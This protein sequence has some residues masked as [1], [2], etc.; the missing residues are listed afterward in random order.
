MIDKLDHLSIQKIYLSNDNIIKLNKQLNSLDNLNYLIYNDIIDYIFS[1]K[2]EEIY[3]KL[4]SSYFYSSEFK[5]SIV[6]NRYFTL[7]EHIKL[8]NNQRILLF[9]LKKELFNSYITYGIDSNLFK[10]KVTKY[11]V[12]FEKF[13]HI[14]S[15]LFLE[16][17]KY[18][19]SHYL[20]DMDINNSKKA[21]GNC[22]RKVNLLDSLNL[23]NESEMGYLY[24]DPY[25]NISNKIGSYFFNK[26]FIKKS[27][28]YS[29]LYFISLSIGFACFNHD[30]NNYVYQLMVSKN[31]Y[32]LLD[33]IECFLEILIELDIETQVDLIEIFIYIYTN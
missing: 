13:I 1:R 2:V 32:Q 33:I 20:L 7:N 17:S 3:I 5:S 24:N 26:E 30:K 31:R 22:L 4:I 21:I 16:V 6:Y 23:S 19:S 9:K 28:A 12:E 10:E 15:D 11:Y 18:T 14:K 27:L 25:Y 29:I 8:Y